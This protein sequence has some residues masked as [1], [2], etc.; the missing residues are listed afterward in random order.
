[1]VNASQHSFTK[2]TTLPRNLNMFLARFHTQKGN[3]GIYLF[4]PPQLS[5]KNQHSDISKTS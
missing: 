5:D 3:F 1:M 2:N 4:Y